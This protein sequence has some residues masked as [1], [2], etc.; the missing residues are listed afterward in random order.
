MNN[1][2]FSEVDEENKL[3]AR[4]LVAEYGHYLFNE[5]KL[6]AGHD[7]FFKELANFPDDKYKLPV[8]GFFV[9]YADGDAIGCLG[10]KKFDQ[11]S[12]ELKRMYIREQLR[13]RGFAKELVKFSINEA[14]ALGYKRMLLD[15]N[16]EMPAAVK[17]YLAAGFV[18]IP[19]YCDNDGP[20]PMF[21]AY[22]L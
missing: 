1:I 16:K 2:T 20:N 12:C 14:R 3:I 9:V 15:T 17:A 13:G 8:G 7:T 11:T 10:L 19:A 18:E 22:Y 5:L 6:M 4:E 21:F